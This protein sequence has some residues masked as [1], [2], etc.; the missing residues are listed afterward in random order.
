ME[1]AHTRKYEGT[2]LGLPIVKSLAELRG[3]SFMIESTLGRGTTVRIAFPGSRVKEQIGGD[4][5]A[6]PKW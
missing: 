5:V 1:N 6:S 3:T 2:G 4:T